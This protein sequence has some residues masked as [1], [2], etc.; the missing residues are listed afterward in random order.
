M[1]SSYYIIITTTSQKSICRDAKAAVVCYA[2][3]D[4]ESW[5]KLTFWISELKKM[6]ENCRIY[7]CATKT[8]LLK[9]NN[10]NRVIDYHNTTDFCEEINAKLYETSSKSGE[11]ITEMFQEIAKDYVDNYDET[12]SQEFNQTKLETCKPKKSCCGGRGRMYL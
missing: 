12:D 7:V 3:N 11:N 9:G 10:K 2:V 5:E 6:E 1:G 8:D 4:E